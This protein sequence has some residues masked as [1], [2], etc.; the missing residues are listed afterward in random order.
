MVYCGEGATSE[1]DFNEACNLAGVVRAPLVV[2]VQNNGYAISTRAS[3]QTAAASIAVRAEGYGFP[4]VMVDGND[5]FAVYHAARDAILRARSGGGPTLIETRTYRM[6]IHNTTDDW[7]NYRPESEVTEAGG[8][9][10]I[11]RVQRYLAGRGL[12]DE[13]TAGEYAQSISTEVL[14]ACDA[15]SRYPKAAP[16]GVFEHVYAE[17]PQR[18]LD[19]QRELLRFLDA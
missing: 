7:K 17:P 13:E 2:V 14:S 1:G 4:G 12:W 10:P 6:G 5:L 19:E 15:A 3:V 9:D 16:T 11:L 8:L 18:V